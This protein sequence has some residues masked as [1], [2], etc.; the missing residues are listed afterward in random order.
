MEKQ[1]GFGIKDCSTKASLGRK[2]FG[3]NNKDREFYNFND[4]NIREFTRKSI[5]GGRVAASN[6][7]FE[8]NHCEEILNTKK[9]FEN[10]W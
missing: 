10:D 1:S 8:S 2:C 5:K 3:R 9:T 4:K 7:H 6:R